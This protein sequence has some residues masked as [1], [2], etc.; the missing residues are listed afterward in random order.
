VKK[1]RLVAASSAAALAVLV[2]SAATAHAATPAY[3][4]SCTYYTDF[5]VFSGALH[6]Y[7]TKDCG[8]GSMPA[9]VVLER[10]SAGGSFNYVTSGAGIVTY[11]CQGSTVY[12]YEILGDINPAVT[13]TP[14]A[15][16]C[17]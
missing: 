3:G 16:A 17:G 4:Q 11:T 1:L 5:A 10:A 8:S 2:P 7:N 9:Y 12:T 14:G 6:I 13:I 15:I